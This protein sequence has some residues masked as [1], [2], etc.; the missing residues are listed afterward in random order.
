MKKEETAPY[1]S[2]ER[3]DGVG[4]FAN[5]ETTA[6]LSDL[7]MRRQCAICRAAAEWQDSVN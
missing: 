5:Y 4:P 2:D 6:G 3:R 1:R 7:H